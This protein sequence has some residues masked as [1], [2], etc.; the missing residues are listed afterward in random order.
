M[1]EGIGTFAHHIGITVQT[2]IALTNVT[3]VVM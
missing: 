1:S 3:N 2:G